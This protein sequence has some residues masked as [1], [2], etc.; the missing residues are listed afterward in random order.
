MRFTF[1]PL[2]S[3]SSG[4]ALFIGAGD[5]RILIDAGMP[6][7]A[8]E[9]ALK[10]IGI[11]PEMLTG[12]A[13]TH[14]HSDHVKGV[15]IL[16]RKYH[17]PVYANERTF[18]AMARTVG[19][20][21]PGNRRYFND[22]EDFYIGDLALY[23][24]SIPHDAADPVGYRVYYGGHSVAT[25]T[26]MGYMKKQVLK[27]LSGVD[28]LLLES[29]HDPDL[30]MQ[31]PHYSMYLKQRIL[32]NHGHLSN[33]ASAKALLSLYETGVR[34]VLLGHLSGENNTP[35]LA[36]STAVE[37]LCEAGISVNEDIGVGLAWRDRVS[38]KFEIE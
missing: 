19:E 29:N 7:K 1:C 34:Q 31:N 17:I 22:E 5:T 15:G 9:G 23:P 8:I 4:N 10:E 30:L 36:L 28:V 21:A 18:Q 33:E 13:V 26:D 20:I 35:E 2:F 32:S 16:S 12:I 11:L 25:A 27:T 24:F 14:E 37:A 3:G 38:R 6:G